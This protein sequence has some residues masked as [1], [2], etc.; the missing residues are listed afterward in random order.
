MS[1]HLAAAASALPLPLPP[2]AV[3]APSRALRALILSRG[4]AAAVCSS[5][6]RGGT[7]ACLVR[8]LCSHHSAAAAATALE[9]A[10]RGRKQLGMTP[11]LYDYLLANVREHPI[12][13]ELREETAAMRGSQMQV[14]PAQAQ[15]LSMLVQILGARRCIEVGVFIISCCTGPS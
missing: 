8:R 13:R 5:L 4:G 3:A 2:P 12:L 15:L 1:S 10:R 7:P 14:S 9:E 11:A 6:R